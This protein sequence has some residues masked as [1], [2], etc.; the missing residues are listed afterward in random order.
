MSLFDLI[1][2]NNFEVVKGKMKASLP[3]S[4]EMLN[5]LIA[6]G[7][8][9]IKYIEAI[10]ITN[11]DNGIA[12][13]EITYAAGEIAGFKIDQ[14]QYE[15]K[16]AIHREISFPDVALKIEIVEGVNFIENEILEFAFYAFVESE[17]LHF[18]NKIITLNQKQLSDNPTFQFLINHLIHADVLA[19]RDVLNYNLEFKF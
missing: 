14:S 12:T 6:R 18:R 2:Q 15:Y 8:E 9:K 16:I 5:V 17:L 19:S 7:I 1:K 4:K 10:N 13:L 11:I 3:F